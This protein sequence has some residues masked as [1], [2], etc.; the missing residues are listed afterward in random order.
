MTGFLLLSLLLHAL[1][2]YAF[3]IIYPPAIALLAPPGRVTVIAPNTTEERVLLRWLEAEDPALASTTQPPNQ[4]SLSVPTIQHA[5]F[6][7]NHR[8]A[9]KEVPPFTP[10][11][12]IPS[13]HPPAPVGPLPMPIQT[14][15]RLSPTTLRFSEE[16]ETV[17]AAQIPEMKFT[18]SG[19]EI[20]QPVQFRVAVGEKGDI[21]Y[22]FLE[23]SS[24][25]AALDEQAREYVALCRFP[26]IRQPPLGPEL[27]AEGQSEIR[28]GLVWGTATIEW[29]NDIGAPPRA[30]TESV[31][32]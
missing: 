30:A 2:F 14:A 11:P 20:P 3:Q 26:A 17:N 25:D 4:T 28:N 18:A 5:P 31:A 22:C 29:G 6:Y 19:H 15:T 27:V 23:N 7:M 13:A 9:L 32:P 8:P 10:N 1:C 16:L 24:G 12:G 21:H